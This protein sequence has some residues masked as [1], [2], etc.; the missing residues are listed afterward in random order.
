MILNFSTVFPKDKGKLSGLPTMFP[1]KIWK[2]IAKN[3]WK[4]LNDNKEFFEDFKDND[5]YAMNGNFSGKEKNTTIRRDSK[6]RWKV[7]MKIHFY[8]GARTKKSFRFAPVLKVKSVNKIQI[9]YD[10]AICNQ[11]KALPC[12]L[13]DDV[14]LHPKHYERLAQ[15]DGFDSLEDFF[16]WFNKDFV[17]KLIGW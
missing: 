15:N 2:G 7:G 14:A 16:I 6:D 3:H 12:I 5:T 1:E 10:S 8:I 17:G 13:I 11:F 9:T 4:I